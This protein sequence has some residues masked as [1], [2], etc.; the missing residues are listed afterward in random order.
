MTEMEDTLNNINEM[1]AIW[2][3]TS[4]EDNLNGRQSHWKT[5]TI[6]DKWKSAK[7]SFQHL[8]PRTVEYNVNGRQPPRKTTLMEIAVN[9]LNLLQSLEDILI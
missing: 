5:I 1:P 8:R 4:I 2:T 9:L 3:T 6:K 7:I